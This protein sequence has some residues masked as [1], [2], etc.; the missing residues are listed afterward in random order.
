[1]EGKKTAQQESWTPKEFAERYRVSRATVYN[2][3]ERGLLGSVK[4][5]GARRILREHDDAFRS[6]LV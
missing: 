3:F 6:R 4:I 5:G 1:M 2:W